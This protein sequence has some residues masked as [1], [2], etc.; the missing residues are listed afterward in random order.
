[1]IT[2]S[3][4]GS[5]SCILYMMCF[6]TPLQLHREVDP[7]VSFVSLM[8]FISG[9]SPLSGV[10]Q[11]VG[12]QLAPV[13]ISSSWPRILE[14]PE[15]RKLLEL[16]LKWLAH[17]SWCLHGAPVKPTWNVHMPNVMSR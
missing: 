7:F 4:S 10:N 16:S 9:R 3:L 8:T 5:S 17:A 6:G 1:M 11:P 15:S 2:L 13:A 12:T 14:S